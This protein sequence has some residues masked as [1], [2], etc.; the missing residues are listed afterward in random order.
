MAKKEIGFNE[1]MK[2]I[3]QILRNIEEGEPDIDRLS[4][5]VR[6]AAELIKI[7]RRRLRETGEKIDGIMEELR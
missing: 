7:C 5:N 6:K 1:A 4:E 3:E 2:G